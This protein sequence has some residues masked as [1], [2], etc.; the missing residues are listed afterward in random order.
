[1]LSA[2]T[3]VGYPFHLN[4]RRRNFGMNSWLNDLPSLADRH[5]ANRVEVHPDDASRL[6][7]HGGDL[8]EVS[9]PVGRIELAALVTDAVRR[10]S[11][12]VDHG[13]GSRVFDPAG[14]DPPAGVGANRN[15]L[16]DNQAVDPLSG[17]AAF[18]DRF[19]AVALVRSPQVQVLST[20]HPQESD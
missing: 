1:M 5:P 12:C 4:N 6:G 20:P 11:V 14:G 7:I 17:T 15:L 3:P 18:N 16:I 2:T 10:G 13:F 19:V 9:S 8:V